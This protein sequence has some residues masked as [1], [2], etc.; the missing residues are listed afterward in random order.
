MHRSPERLWTFVTG[1]AGHKSAGNGL[2][3]N[4][5][6]VSWQKETQPGGCFLMCVSP[7]V[8]QPNGQRNTA[9][10]NWQAMLSWTSPAK[11]RLLGFSQT[12]KSS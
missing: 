4:T 6:A 5:T 1:G 7:E 9:G 12:L 11:R 3:S 10:P 8:F 2:Q